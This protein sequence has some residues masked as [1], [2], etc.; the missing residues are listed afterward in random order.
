[1]LEARLDC[2]NEV[3]DEAVVE[4]IELTSPDEARD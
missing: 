2:S 4:D 3:I 1:M